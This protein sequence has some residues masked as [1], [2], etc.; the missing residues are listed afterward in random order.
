MMPTEGM[1]IFFSDIKK[2]TQHRRQQRVQYVLSMITMQLQNINMSHS[3]SQQAVASN[4]LL[5]QISLS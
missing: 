4:V 1:R 2:R 5:A 3:R